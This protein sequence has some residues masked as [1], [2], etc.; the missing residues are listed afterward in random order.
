[1]GLTLTLELFF[2][3]YVYKI[4]FEINILLRLDDKTVDNLLNAVEYA[5]SRLPSRTNL[6]IQYREQIERDD[7]KLNL[8]HRIQ[9]T[10]ERSSTNA[11]AIC[12]PVLF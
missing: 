9:E 1:M 2:T 12:L 4:F 7:I 5:I 6:G 11:G 8:I 10:S 3:T